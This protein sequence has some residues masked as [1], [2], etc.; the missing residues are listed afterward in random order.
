MNNKEKYLPIG[1]VCLLKDG[2][3]RVM[4]T[5]FCI[6]PESG[7]KKVYDYCGCIYPEGILTTDKSIVFNHEQ[8]DKI[9]YMGYS[10][11]EEK[12]FKANLNEI[13]KKVQ[14]GEI[15]IDE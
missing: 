7:E 9:Y 4:I 3:K 5:G 8:I 15:N 11:D 2:K 6:V 10:D 14:S 12:K 13:V 1:T